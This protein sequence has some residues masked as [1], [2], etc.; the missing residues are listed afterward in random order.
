MKRLLFVLAVLVP[1]CSQSVSV[2]L[3]AF[4]TEVHFTLGDVLHTVHGTFK[5]RR[6]DLWF[7]P[8][9]GKAGGQL[10]VDA[11]SGESGNHARDSR[12]SKN[13][14]QTDRYPGITFTPDRI[15]GNVSTPGNSEFRL[16]GL[17]TLHG[18][19]HEITMNIKSHIQADR[20]TARA[21]FDVPY[22]KWGIK[23]PSTLFLRVN[24]TVQIQI[25]AAGR[26]STKHTD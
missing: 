24:D 11:A 1:A 23:N 25:E 8:S 26:L 22:E 21:D 19:T 17:F 14:L 16:H 3:D 18:V 10:V 20:L 2:Q 15:E 13:F 5:F 12:M 9:T 6:G 4:S 7:D